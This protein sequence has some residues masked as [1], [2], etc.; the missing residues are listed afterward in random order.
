VEVAG[1]ENICKIH[2][3]PDP[4]GAPGANGTTAVITSPSIDLGLGPYTHIIVEEEAVEVR[5]GNN[6][7]QGGRQPITAGTS[8]DGG[9]GGNAD[10]NDATAGNNG[11]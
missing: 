3:T 10:T 4:E 5:G 8:G 6:G 2:F 11:M 7:G 9:M 1:K